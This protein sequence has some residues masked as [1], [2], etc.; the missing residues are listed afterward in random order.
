MECQRSTSFTFVL[1]HH[2]D[3]EDELIE[4]VENIITYMASE[5]PLQSEQGL[6]DVSIYIYIFTHILCYKLN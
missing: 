6:V 1:G 3:I 4:N 2:P 5:P